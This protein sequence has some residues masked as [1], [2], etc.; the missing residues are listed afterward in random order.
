MISI[1]SINSTFKTFYDYI[2]ACCG[3]S[4]NTFDVNIVKE[5]EF[6]GV[7][8]ILIHRKDKKEKHIFVDER[9]P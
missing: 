9:R 5:M 4:L 7:V 6:L 3:I 2:D 8:T 1:N